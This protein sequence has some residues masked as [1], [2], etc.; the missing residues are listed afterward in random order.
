MIKSENIDFTIQLFFSEI[1]NEIIILMK[2]YKEKH[3]LESFA[4]TNHSYLWKSN[5]Q[6]YSLD[7]IYDLGKL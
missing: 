3:A 5:M 2:N 6:Y 4:P 1:T 7:L